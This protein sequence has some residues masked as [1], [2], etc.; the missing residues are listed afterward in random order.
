MFY[1]Q[2]GM[3][4]RRS[5]TYKAIF[6]YTHT[7]QCYIIEIPVTTSIFNMACK[8]FQLTEYKLLNIILI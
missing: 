5:Q 4:T 2:L 6:Q 1:C 3:H 8:W 7:T